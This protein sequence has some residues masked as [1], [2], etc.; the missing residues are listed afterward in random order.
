MVGSEVFAL[1]PVMV[2]TPGSGN[3]KAKAH[4]VFH[5]YLDEF[6]Q[7]NPGYSYLVPSGDEQRLKSE[8]SEGGFTV[9]QRPDGRQAFKVWK[10]VHPE[11]Y[12]IGW[13]EA[14]E[15]EFSPSRF[16][17]FHHMMTIFFLPPALLGSFLVTWITGRLL[18]RIVNRRVSIES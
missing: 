5:R 9:E 8:L 11:A 7:K 14:S 3:E 12:T 4:L 2:V 15:K 1:F 18:K 16:S 10:T 17:L 13:Y 6:L